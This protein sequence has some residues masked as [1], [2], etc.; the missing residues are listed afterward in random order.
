M[1]KTLKG[2]GI[3]V[4][5][6]GPQGFK[7]KTE[8]THNSYINL[9]CCRNAGASGMGDSSAANQQQ[10]ELN[11]TLDLATCK[12]P[13]GDIY[14]KDICGFHKIDG[15]SVDNYQLVYKKKFVSNYQLGSKEKCD[16]N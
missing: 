6:E 12:P 5:P 11:N 14:M 7:N 9:L 2:E 13:S 1:S 4:S 15:F 8:N 16:S 3:L 10:R